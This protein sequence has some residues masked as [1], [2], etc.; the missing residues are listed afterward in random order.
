[1]DNDNEIV[2]N[3]FKDNGLKQLNNSQTV[4]TTNS[5]NEHRIFINNIY[6]IESNY[7]MNNN[8]NESPK[9]QTPQSIN[10]NNNNLETKLNNL[11]LTNM[12]NIFL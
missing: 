7:N 3:A 12:N 10:N 5:I 1:M 8:N 6:S 2:D 4:Q 11:N 9:Q